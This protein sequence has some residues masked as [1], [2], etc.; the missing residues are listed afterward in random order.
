MY[1]YPHG[2]GSIPVLQ[3]EPGQPF[4]AVDPIETG[5][6]TDLTRLLGFYRPSNAPSSAMSVQDLHR[7]SRLFLI[8]TTSLLFSLAG[9][10]FT[11]Y[12]SLYEDTNGY[13]GTVGLSYNRALWMFFFSNLAHF[14]YEF[15]YNPGKHLLSDERNQ[16]LA[17]SLICM[18]F[19]PVFWR[20]FKPFSP[21][22]LYLYSLFTSLRSAGWTIILTLKSPG[23]LA[24]H[25][26]THTLSLSLTQ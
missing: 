16:W 1:E 7:Q 22:S 14:A 10:G 5:R 18:F 4:F 23:S 9:F 3:F 11:W 17:L 13:C 24:T 2:S 21:F 26:H 8:H 19:Y 6:Q 12:T 25:T 20:T 15:Q